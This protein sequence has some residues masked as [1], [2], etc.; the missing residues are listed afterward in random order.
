MGANDMTQP[1]T[2]KDS[3]HIKIFDTTLRD[4]QQCP[5][6]GMSFD[7]NIEYARLACDLRIDVLEA[8]FP[9]AS[10]LDF[11]IV[12]TIAKEIT[13]LNHKP[14]VAALCQLRE[15]QVIRTI[16]ALTPLTAL[17]RSRV[18]IYLPVDPELMP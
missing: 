14:I 10:H 16:E 2:K 11:E 7:N 1:R 12:Q 13:R 18:H 17:H 3:H 9:A 8:G 4:G 15:E 5:G 6:A